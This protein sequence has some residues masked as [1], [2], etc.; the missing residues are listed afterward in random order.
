MPKYEILAGESV[1]WSVSADDVQTAKLGAMH[2]AVG[3]ALGVWGGTES[4]VTEFYLHL[5]CPPNVPVE[6]ALS[7][8]GEIREFSARV[9]V[10]NKAL[11]QILFTDKFI[12]FRSEMKAGFKKLSSISEQRNKIAHGTTIEYYGDNVFVP[13]FSGIAMLREQRLRR[14]KKFTSQVKA[15]E[16]WSASE[17][18]IRCHEIRDSQLIIVGLLESLCDLYSARGDEISALNHLSLP[19]GLPVNTDSRGRDTINPVEYGQSLAAI[20]KRGSDDG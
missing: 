8:M 10:I 2:L 20:S 3:S 15:F 19:N 1:K 6:G 14:T 17:L 13:Y 9:N 16:I 4:L 5:V 12:D 11:G 18:I 7:T